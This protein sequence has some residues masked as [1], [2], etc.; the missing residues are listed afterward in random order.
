MKRGRLSASDLSV[1]GPNTS[2]TRP[3]LIPLQPLKSSEKRVFDLIV[4]ENAHLRQTDVPLLMGLA[5]ATAGLFGVETA[6]DFEKLARVQM[7]YATRLRITP[8][9]RTHPTTLGR[10]I[11]DQNN[12]PR[13]WDRVRGGED[14]NKDE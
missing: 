5:R 4:R 14:S 12:G 9:A 7:S 2:G 8:Q 11:A 3:P 1:V 10:R 13:P 6:G